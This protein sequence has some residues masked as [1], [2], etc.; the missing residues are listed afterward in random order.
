MKLKI[1]FFQLFLILFPI[2]IF[3][4]QG[5][6]KGRIFDES[7]NEPIPFANIIVF[8][9]TIGSS[10][11]LDGNYTFT[12]LKPGFVKLAVSAV[13][14][15]VKVTEDFQVT[16]AKTF[17]IDIPMKPKEFELQEVV[18]SASPFARIEESP[19][20]LRTLQISEIEKNPGGNRDI[21]RVIQILPGVSSTP[22]FRN[23]IIVRGGG[24]NENVF[25]V[26]GVEI[27]N[28]NHFSTQGSSGGPVGII[29]ADFIRE[30][31]FYS[32]AFPADKG[33][34]LSSILDMKLL[35][36][37][38]DKLIVRGSLG[39]TD[40][41]LTL[42]GPVSKKS[43]FLAS[44][45]RSYLQFLFDVLGLP[46]LPT[47][48][49]FLAKYKFDFDQ[50]NQLSIIGLGSIDKFKLN[51]GLENP[52]ASQS[53][54]L[55]YLP[56]NEQWSYTIGATYKHFWENGFTDV[57][58]SRNM[59]NNRSY[60]YQNNDETDPLN[61]IYDYNS[62][63]A[64]NKLRVEHTSRRA[65]LKYTYGGGLDFAKYSNKTFQKVYQDG[66]NDTI[67]YDSKINL[68]LWNAFGQVSKNFFDDRL[69][70]SFGL[71][72]DA[73]NYT[74]YMSNLLHQ[75]S[76][77]LSASYGI[78]ESFFLNFNT[79]RYYQRAPYTSFGFRD[80][81][82]VLVNKVN[83]IR[84]LSADH[85]V[86][87][88]EYLPKK[89]AKISLE[90]F[91]KYYRNYPFSV[92]DSINIA[93]KSAGY[94]TFGD[95]EI[96]SVSKGRAYGFEVLAQDKSF[97]GFNVILSYTFVIS[98]FTDKYSNFVPSAWDNRNII[99][100]TVLRSFKK[101]W[102]IGAKWRFVGGAP[103]TPADLELS[104]IVPAWDV[105]GR[106]YPDYNQFNALR[107]KA[108]HQL[109]IRVDKTY[110]FKKW[111][112]NLYVD[113]QN[114]YNFKAENPPNY[115]NLDASGNKVYQDPPQ[116]QLYQLS[117]LNSESGTILP[118]VGIIVEI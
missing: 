81:N 91:Y 99:N 36:G 29:N 90:G 70:L 30:V 3:A 46:F 7:N 49:D 58:L 25:Y 114:V 35:D 37:N 92:Q 44:Y 112:L 86:F 63:E 110:Y 93:S 74:S 17:F 106:E 104:S 24:G 12:G 115:T 66:Q 96:I 97:F 84:Y 48:D 62:T 64:E 85:V 55:G 42:N 51:T 5:S 16:N 53:Y 73:N 103:Y 111:S 105:R 61:K 52:D 28:I 72:M 82:E 113:L 18:I 76:P 109:D 117:P 107:L 83:D 80:N 9:T 31:E 45:R 26:D 54:I 43:T 11:D 88:F 4:Q 69:I 101:N 22:A 27:P 94:G 34:S 21:S 57:V 39:A 23:D 47:Y 40:L 95:E 98:K 100:L 1:I 8:G 41:A 32:G 68:F 65:T 15:E 118:S 59:L 6:I 38:H 87:G 50:K 71:R 10:S 2:L 78:T 13:G 56:V 60:K 75:V 79:G 89:D 33:K 108:F 14:F 116:N 102:D 77:R 67:N 19:L 20:S